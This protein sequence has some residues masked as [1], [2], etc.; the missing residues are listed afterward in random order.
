MLTYEDKNRVL[1]CNTLRSV[2]TGTEVNRAVMLYEIMHYTR[3]SVIFLICSMKYC[4]LCT[5][6]DLLIRSLRMPTLILATPYDTKSL[7]QSM[8]HRGCPFNAFL[9]V[10]TTWD[11]RL[12]LGTSSNIKAWM[13]LILVINSIYDNKGQDSH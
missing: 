2:A 13:F 8:G 6:C 11:T 1:F 9:G 5:C 7:L 3:Y 12:P 4:A 10:H